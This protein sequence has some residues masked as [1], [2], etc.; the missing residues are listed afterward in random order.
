V[1]RCVEATADWTEIDG[2]G[3]T[4]ATTAVQMVLD[5]HKRGLA[6]QPFAVGA[7]VMGLR[8]A[9]GSDPSW[10]TLHAM[11]GLVVRAGSR[12]MLQWDSVAEEL[13]D[14]GEIDEDW[15]PLISEF[16]A[17]WDAGSRL[18]W[19]AMVKNCWTSRVHGRAAA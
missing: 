17:D 18:L 11:D 5:S 9:D 8:Q 12:R 2:D 3:R 13:R 1:W 4:L 15:Q 6:T 14:A 10:E 19:A 7:R 16:D